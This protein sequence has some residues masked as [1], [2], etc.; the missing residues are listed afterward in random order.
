MA[1]R[2]NEYTFR[3][4]DIIEREE[5][6][7]GKYGA[8]GKK[9]E[10]KKTPTREDMKKVNA[11]NKA[12]KARHKMLTYFGPGDILATW[13]YLVKNRP[14][15]MKEALDDFKKAIRTVRREYKK[16]GYELFWIR[17]IEKGTRGAWHIH[18]IVNEIGDTASILEKAWQK[19]G[20]WAC[21][22]KKS[23]YYD[24]DFT[25][26]GN[27]ITK[28]ENTQKEKE[29][30]TLAKPRI[31]EAS[32]NTSRNMP[33]PKPHADKLRRWQKEPKPKKGYYIA[34][35]YEG[36]NP[37]TGYKY[38]RYT[39]FRLNAHTDIGWLDRAT[40]KMQI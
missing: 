2:R 35:I 23:Q 38:R 31:K 12:K 10:K 8:K 21:A 13:G 5:Y 37:K 40:E 34:K 6:H 17:N 39:M 3:G 14:G 16:R 9:R 11:M 28:D 30:G 36:I 18:I 4:G 24:E 20:T 19:G 29:D 26:L 32:Y 15:S 22:I 33:L 27:Y 1:T 25:E 7:D